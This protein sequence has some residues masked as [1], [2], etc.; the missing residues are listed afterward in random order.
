[1]ENKRNKGAGACQELAIRSLLQQAKESRKKK[2][3]KAERYK[4][5]VS[6]AKEEKKNELKVIENLQLRAELEEAYGR[7]KELEQENDSLKRRPQMQRAR[8][9]A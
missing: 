5:Q 4:K 1:M 2:A 7:I 3:L 6:N 8:T 9:Q